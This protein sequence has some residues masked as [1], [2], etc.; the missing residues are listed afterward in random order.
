MRQCCRIFILIT[1][2]S[3]L[4]IYPQ[5]SGYSGLNPGGS[6][7]GTADQKG[8][9]SG[10]IN[11]KKIYPPNSR[12]VIP[13][14][15]FKD[16]DLR[17]ILRSIAFEYHTN[18]VVDNS[19][20]GRASAALFN[21]SVLNAIE[22]IA[23]DNGYDFSYDSLRFYIKP[24]KVK[25]PPPVPEYEPEVQFNKGKLSLKLMNA[26]VNKFVEK[27]RSATGKNFLLNQGTS[28]R[29]SGELKNVELETGLKNILQNNGFFL[30]ASDSIFYIARSGYFSSLEGSNAPS[31]S[32]GY[33]VNAR[34]NRVTLDVM[35]AN[36]DQVLTDIARQM[37]LQVVKLAIPTAS[38]TV[39]CTEVPLDVALGYLFKGTE[40][41]FREENGAYVIGPKTSKNLDNTKLLRLK[42]LRADK[43]KE[44]L[45]QAF[46]QGISVGV[47]LEHNAI[48]ASGTNEAVANLEDYL[49]AIDRPVPQVLIEALVVDYNLDNMLQYGITAGRGD[50]LA[51]SRPSKYY[52]GVDVT[53]SG[54][55]V[56]K[57]L[58]SIG[59][60]NLFGKDLDVAK[61]GKLPDD[62]YMNLK[63][64]EQHGIANVKSKPLLSSLNGHT[65][66]L[67]IG[68]VQNYV[69]NEIMPIT[70]QVNSTFIERERI[71]KI[72]ANISFEIT[73]WVGPN[74]ELTLEIKPEFQTPIGPFVPDKKLIPAINTRSMFSTLRL[75]DG[76]TIILGGLIQ[77]SETNMEDK[78][79]FLGDIPFIGKFFTNVDKKKSKGEL[80]IYLTPRISY[81]D[82]FGNSY[83]EYS[84]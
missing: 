21:V 33:W 41:S 84:K 82:D 77:E 15:N 58:N 29:L 31:K 62:F 83:Y 65:A 39:R 71:E 5:E 61:L 9:P 25:L 17:D 24:M 23:R 40:F 47:S 68:T 20:N 1:I 8:V 50:S 52:P 70:S 64:M 48:I 46:T 73:P 28:G 2:F 59:T 49:Q 27:L 14:L 74:S 11:P 45:P 66:S 18:I 13:A 69:F 72:E 60:I 3:Y 57:L 7:S 10:E 80:I 16:T 26:D 6:Y 44:T 30:T 36:L 34:N 43:I 79:P 76:E 51:S 35:Q 56:N 22:M 32:A 75:K 12:E 38:V 54:S 55:K 53:L 78:V 63:L 4:N 19:I 67:K 37:G 42:Y 81:G